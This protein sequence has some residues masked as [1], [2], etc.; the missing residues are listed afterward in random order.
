MEKKSSVGVTILGIFIFISGVICITSNLDFVK[1]KLQYKE[2]LK[3]QISQSLNTMLSLS[4]RALVSIE[5]NLEK[6]PPKFKQFYESKQIEKTSDIKDLKRYLQPEVL[7]ENTNK[8]VNSRFLLLDEVLNFIFGIILLISSIGIF[9]RAS[10]LGKLVYVTIPMSIIILLDLIVGTYL[11]RTLVCPLPQSGFWVI[12]L[13]LSILA[14][15]LIGYN[16]FIYINFTR[17]RVKEQFK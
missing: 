13:M 1:P 9:I 5:K 3:R 8:L 15:L 14:A 2:E 7:E 12:F 16:F 4:E 11:Q 10:W 6:S 17:P